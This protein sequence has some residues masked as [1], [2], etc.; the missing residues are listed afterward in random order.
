MNAHELLRTYRTYVGQSEASEV[1][2]RWSFI[3][4]LSA[5]LGRRVM[6]S[7]GHL[8][9][10]PNNYFIIIG[11]PAS[12]KSTAIKLAR[13]VLELTQF[14]KFAATQTSKEQFLTDLLAAGELELDSVSQSFVCA[15]ELN[16]FFCDASKA[17]IN[18]MME[19]YDADD[20]FEARFRGAKGP[21]LIT[22]PTITMLGGNTQANFSALF[23]PQIITN[24]FLSRVLLIHGETTGRKLPWGG[25]LETGLEEKLVGHLVG[26]RENLNGK[27]RYE[28]AAMRMLEKIY[29]TWPSIEDGRFSYYNQRRYSHLIKLCTILCASGGSMLLTEDVVVLS[30]TLLCS[31]EDGFTRALG[32]FGKSKWSDETSH[33]M[34]LL[35]A[36]KHPIKTGDLWA[37][38]QTSME[39]MDQFLDLLAG[40]RSSGKIT[41]VEDGV[42][43]VRPPERKVECVDYSLLKEI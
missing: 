10:A 3:A 8:H 26:V 14:N 4:V 17:F 28:P 15:P 24:G 37:S 2:H 32:E 34:E 42:I 6:S 23:P 39:R 41:S 19:L 30:N 22:F 18:T 40:L 12:R 7:F 11:E 36:A 16:N 43:A 27:I 9:F 31:I 33:I 25:M 38:V 35:Y 20:S 29:A 5:N 21:Q 1:L 13:R